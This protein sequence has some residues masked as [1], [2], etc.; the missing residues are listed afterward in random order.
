MLVRASEHRDAMPP[1]VV[2]RSY[3]VN[4]GDS[5][6]IPLNSRIEYGLRHPDSTLDVLARESGAARRIVVGFTALTILNSGLTHE[7]DARNDVVRAGEESDRQSDAGQ[8]L[9][10]ANQADNPPFVRRIHREEVTPRDQEGAQ[11]HDLQEGLDLSERVGRDDD[12]AAQ[13]ESAHR[14]DAELTHGD[15]DRDP[16]RHEL[17]PGQQG[18]AAQGQGLVGDGVDEAPEVG[19]LVP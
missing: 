13:E 11:R 14:G 18:E 5:A 17:L 8:S 1:P 6:D 19:D 2:S 16:P 10:E 9:T 4:A 3:R 7:L 12:S 15:E